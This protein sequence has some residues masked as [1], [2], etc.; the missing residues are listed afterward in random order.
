MPTARLLGDSEPLSVNAALTFT[1]GTMSP[2]VRS[3]MS[4]TRK[5]DHDRVG[6]EQ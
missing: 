3:S 5:V 6:L 4:T 2:I 1:S